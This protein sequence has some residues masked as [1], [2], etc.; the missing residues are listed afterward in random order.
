M[1]GK[2]KDGALIAAPNKITHNG[3]VHYNPTDKTYAEAGYLP[4]VETPSPTDA[5]DTYYEGRYEEQDGKIFRVW[6]RAE[7]PTPVL[8]P[9]AERIVTRIREVYSVDDEIALLR[10]KEAKP[11]EFAEYYAF[12]E[13]IKAEEKAKQDI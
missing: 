2:I 1:F 8:P 4:I 5:D 9:Y 12:V 6:E 13:Q 11:E 3:Y 7:K 10:Q